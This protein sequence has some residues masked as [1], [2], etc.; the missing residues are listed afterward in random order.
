M[1]RRARP[2]RGECCGGRGRTGANATAGPGD[3]WGRGAANGGAGP[4][5][6]GG[7]RLAFGLV[8]DAR[9]GDAKNE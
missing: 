9:D 6:I 2:D 5:W 3:E 8:E 1:L 7:T 4:W